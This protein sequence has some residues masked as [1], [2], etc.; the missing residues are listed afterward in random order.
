MNYFK[1]QYSDSLGEVWSL[2]SGLASLSKEEIMGT[3]RVCDYSHTTE[4]ISS[5]MNGHLHQD[6]FDLKA[7]E[8]K[9]SQ[10]DDIEYGK[11][12]DRLLSIVDT[13][14][15]KDEVTVGYG[16]ISSNDKR[17]RSME[18]AFELLEDSDEFEKCLA[19]LFN[20]RKDYIIEKGVDPVEMLVNSL[21]GIPEAVKNMKDLVLS[22]NVLKHIVEVLCENGVNALQ[23]RLEIAY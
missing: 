3:N 15:G 12:R 13:V 4:I 5:A 6:N 8:I 10:N 2:F 20:I 19:E 22:D 7:Y 14:N 17:L 16:E 23:S 9:C 18:D 11:A 1:Y 21:D